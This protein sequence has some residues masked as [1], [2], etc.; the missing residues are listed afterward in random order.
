MS[1]ELTQLRFDQLPTNETY[2]LTN[3][4]N[5][6]LSSDGGSTN[7]AIRNLDIGVFAHY[8]NIT[9]QDGTQ[10]N[11]KVADPSKFTVLL[12]SEVTS[13]DF[14]ES[15]KNTMIPIINKV[16]VV[17][18][19]S[20]SSADGQALVPKLS[21]GTK[22]VY[23]AGSVIK[24]MSNTNGI[25]KGVYHIKAINYNHVPEIGDYPGIAN[26]AVVQGYRLFVDYYA[27]IIRDFI[28]MDGKITL[29]LSQ[30]PDRNFG[31]K[32][33]DFYTF[34]LKTIYLVL[35]LN[36]LPIDKKILFNLGVDKIDEIS[37]EVSEEYL[38][39]LENFDKIY[40]V[41]NPPTNEPPTKLEST[42]V[43]AHRFN[44]KLNG[45]YFYKKILPYILKEVSGI[46]G[47]EPSIN[48][49]TGN[50]PSSNPKPA[51]GT[52]SIA[53]PVN[54]STV[55]MHPQLATNEGTAPINATFMPPVV[56]IPVTPVVGIPVND[57]QEE[58]YVTFYNTMET[59]INDATLEEMFSGRQIV[60][61]D[62]WV[63]ELYGK[64]YNITKIKMIFDY[65]RNLNNPYTMSGGSTLEDFK[66]YIR[67]QIRKIKISQ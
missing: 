30:Y 56:G 21:I 5:E 22:Q 65:L 26:D 11:N 28:K 15:M 1:V 45:G 61:T 55:G 10:L 32:A 13:A 6:I 38:Q 44:L 20:Y 12:D 50:G 46:F 49:P 40:P 23:F 57:P 64:V 18:D 3:G 39:N 66:N 60:T 67:E 47:K 62:I 8:D 41:H 43:F 35:K 53:T 31:G 63:D 34:L 54:E 36:T 58:L 59:W 4:A 9:K 16:G 51:I 19:G 17:P 48:A 24:A 52:P 29:Y 27:A 14:E 42:F 7:E 2:M 37:Q 33:V 25:F